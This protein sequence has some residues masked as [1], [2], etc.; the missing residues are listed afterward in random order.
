MGTVLRRVVLTVAV[1]LVSFGVLWAVSWLWFNRDTST[2][3]E[4]FTEGGFSQIEEG[5][6]FEEV[7]ALLGDPLIMKI[8]PAPETWYYSQKQPGRQDG[9]VW[10]FR[11]SGSLD[12]VE[13]DEQ[14]RV[15]DFSGQGT[16]QLSAGLSKEQVLELLGSPSSMQPARTK[17]LYYSSPG[18]AGVYKARG[19]ELDENDRVSRIIRYTLHD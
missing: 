19:L 14:G 6:P 17:L 7:H 4:D 1:A 3:A 11:L 8:D 2:Y 5:M 18:D 13:F 12:R 9:G 15:I 16:E 10:V